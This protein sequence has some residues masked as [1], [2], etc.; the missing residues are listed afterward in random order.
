MGGR[1]AATTQ[2]FQGEECVV[3]AV[4]HPNPWS[5]AISNIGVR[6]HRC[7]DYDKSQMV[8]HPPRTPHN[9]QH[10]AQ[11]VLVFPLVGLR[12]ANTT[13]NKCSSFL[14]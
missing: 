7:A 9:A 11:Q 13:H 12:T 1:H 10:Y 2:G 5:C 3:L 8:C 4:A 14:L 6:L